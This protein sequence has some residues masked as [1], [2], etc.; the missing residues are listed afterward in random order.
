MTD[1]ATPA[2]EE[3]KTPPPAATPAPVSQGSETVTLTKEEHERLQRD[4]ARAASA[5]SR[6]DRLER[7]RERNGQHFG[8]A[9]QAPPPAPSKEQEEERG[10]EEDVKAERGLVRLAVDPK[11]REIL[12]SD[13][14]LR[15]MITRNPLSLLPIYANDAFDAED[16]IGL[17]REELDKRLASM[18]PATNPTPTTPAPASDVKTPPPGGVNADTRNLDAEYEEA[19]KH[20]S[21]ERAIAGMINLGMKKLGKKS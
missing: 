18:K 1:A 19:R 16:A 20:P 17:V 21:T 9:K 4:A 13:P 14:T 12:D 3:V 7:S 11:Y 8:A 10:H 2:V 6:A 5:Q 15:D